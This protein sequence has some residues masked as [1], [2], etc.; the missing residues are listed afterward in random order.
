MREQHSDARDDVMLV[1]KFISLF[2]MGI[3]IF[4]N[5][6]PYKIP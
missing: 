4:R 3:H 1:N 2:I 5:I 6:Q